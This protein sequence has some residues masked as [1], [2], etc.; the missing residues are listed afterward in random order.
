MATSIATA[1]TDITIYRPSSGGW[2]ILRSGTGFTGGLGYSWGAS[3]DTPVPG[4]YDG[5]GK[6]DLAVYRPPPATGSS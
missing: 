3:T 6:T 4:D 2:F 5:D 1:A